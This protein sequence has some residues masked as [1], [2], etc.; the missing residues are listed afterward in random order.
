MAEI[1]LFLSLR[2]IS[3]TMCVFCSE[4]GNRGRDK[5]RCWWWPELA[6]AGVGGGV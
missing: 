1:H 3:A 6:M 4:D 5:G 2:T